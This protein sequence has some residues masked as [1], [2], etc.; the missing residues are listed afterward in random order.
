MFEFND[1]D[2]YYFTIRKYLQGFSNKQIFPDG[3]YFEGIDKSFSYEGGSG[4]NS[5][6]F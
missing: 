6:T 1:P 5:P 2:F 3:L 4:G